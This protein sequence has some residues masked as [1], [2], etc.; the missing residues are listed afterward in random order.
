MVVLSSFEHLHEAFLSKK[1][2][3][4]NGRVCG[5][6]QYSY[7]GVEPNTPKD[8]IQGIGTSIGSIWRDNRKLAYH[9]LLSK[10]NL[11]ELK[12]SL[13]SEVEFSV[14][15]VEEVVG[16]RLDCL[17]L[18]IKI[19][20]NL[21]TNAAFGSRL[22]SMDSFDFEEDK[23]DKTEDDFYYANIGT[24]DTYLPF[25][26]KFPSKQF[27]RYNSNISLIRDILKT[28]IED[29]RESSSGSIPMMDAMIQNSSLDESGA[30]TLMLDILLA[31][32]D[33]TGKTLS[34]LFLLLAS[35][36]EEQDKCYK[37]IHNAFLE[38]DSIS[39]VDL[40]SLHYIEAVIYETMRLYPAAPLSLPHVC[41]LSQTIGGYDIHEGTVIV[42]N[43]YSIHRDEKNWERANE[44]YPNRF[45][46][47]PELLKSSKLLPFGLGP[48]S[49]IGKDFALMEMKLIVALFLLKFQVESPS[50]GGIDGGISI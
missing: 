35:H 2:K 11:R 32:S 23:G 38:K 40:S 36:Q 22:Y 31:G 34:F 15:Q 9:Y 37:E 8:Q 44:F 45:I 29:Y 7:C 10:K 46:L 1:S 25:M 24:I 39:E 16:M 33:S 28:I 17:S 47:D 5:P 30:V 6:V 48:R 19:S 21:I 50:N 27:L 43:I 49:C 3:Y 26:S 13:A 41:T 12:G 4:F 18:F 42:S 14:Q 20:S